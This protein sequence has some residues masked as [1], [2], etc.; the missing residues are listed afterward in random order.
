[1]CTQSVLSIQ[2]DVPHASRVP[3]R[4]AFYSFMQNTG[5]HLPSVCHPG[6]NARSP[7]YAVPLLLKLVVGRQSQR[8][9]AQSAVYL[10]H[11]EGT[12]AGAAYGSQSL[13]LMEILCIK[14]ILVRPLSSRQQLLQNRC[15]SICCCQP[16]NLLEQS[17]FDKDKFSSDAATEC[18]MTVE[19]CM[20]RGCVVS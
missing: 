10:F 3:Q 5:E 15:K 12:E 6:P 16:V 7:Q 9:H 18:H 13:P 8:I 20:R 4:Q 17:T 1:M 14:H 2:C 11:S 19:T